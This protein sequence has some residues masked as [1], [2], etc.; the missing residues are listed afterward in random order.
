MPT[1]PEVWL[2][3]SIEKHEDG[4]KK[5]KKEDT[6]LRVGAPQDEP[7]MWGGFFFLFFFF[8]RGEAGVAQ[9]NSNGKKL[10]VSCARLG[11]KGVQ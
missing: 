5:K 10:R 3:G 2:I 8:C 7:K 9:M 4:K 1:R 6:R 11:F